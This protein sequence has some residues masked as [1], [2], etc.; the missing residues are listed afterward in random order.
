MDKSLHSFSLP[1]VLKLTA[2]QSKIFVFFSA[3]KETDLLVKFWK[4]IRIALCASTMI[5]SDVGGTCPF[6]PELCVS[7]GLILRLVQMLRI[8]YN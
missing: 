3:K 8:I 5:M 7:A 4:Q 1:F 6:I 2:S